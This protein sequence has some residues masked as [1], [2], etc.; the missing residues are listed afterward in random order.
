MNRVSEA[1]LY[2]KER[3]LLSRRHWE[4]YHT[5]YK[6]SK[7]TAGE[8]SL[9]YKRMSRNHISARL[10]ELEKMGMVKR[11]ELKVSVLSGRKSAVWEI[12]PRKIPLQ[13]RKK[14]RKF[15]INLYEDRIEAFKTKKEAN[16]NIKHGLKE[17]VLVHESRT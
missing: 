3:K 4:V 5:L 9:K 6:M 8:I 15:W 2:V 12:T 13:W 1:Y 10:G 17:T 16:N 14:I 11:G 7:A